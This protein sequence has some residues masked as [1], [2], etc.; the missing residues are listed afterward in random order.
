MLSTHVCRGVVATRPH[1]DTWPPCHHGVSVAVTDGKEANVPAG[2]SP[3][4][5]S[6]RSVRQAPLCL[7][8]LFFLPLVSLRKTKVDSTPTSQVLSTADLPEAHCK[9][10]IFSI[11]TS[12]T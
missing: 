1:L 11:G 10:S 12:V 2:P 3:R 5:A 6:S 8:T 7:H 9:I 4:A